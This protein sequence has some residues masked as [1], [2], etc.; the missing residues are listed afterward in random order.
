M[1]F[2]D[3]L[4]NLLDEKDISQKQFANSL[5]IAPSTLGNYIRNTRE[6]DFDT[7]KLFADYFS[8]SIDYLLSYQSSIANNRTEDEMLRIFRSLT[9]YQQ[10][11]YLEQ[12]KGFIKLNQKTNAG[13]E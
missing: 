2:G 12:G 9:D 11:L 4:R 3:V 5:N 10:E 7:L 1:K 6:P 8:V 13:S